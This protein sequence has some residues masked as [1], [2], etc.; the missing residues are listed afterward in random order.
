L[1]QEIGTLSSGIDE[2]YLLLRVDD[3][4]PA[5]KLL[6]PRDGAVQHTRQIISEISC[7][8]LAQTPFL[9]CSAETTW[10]RDPSQAANPAT[11]PRRGVRGP[12]PA[13]RLHP[14]G[15]HNA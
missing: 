10:D 2:K 6:N 5:M 14:R 13:P 9:P 7:A 4:G 3:R 8:P 15:E 11:A 12:P 1:W